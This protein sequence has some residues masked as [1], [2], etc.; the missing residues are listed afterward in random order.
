MTKSEARAI[1]KATVAAGRSWDIGMNA[2]GQ[3]EMVRERTRREERAHAGRM[4]RWAVRYEAL[5]G[6]PESDDDR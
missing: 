6:A 5:N 2:S 3:F 1:R 4:A